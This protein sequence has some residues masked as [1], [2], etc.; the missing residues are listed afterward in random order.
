MPT[1]T[2]F[3]LLLMK[4]EQQEVA[5]FATR[6]AP[7]ANADIRAV[8]TESHIRGRI[9]NMAPWY[10]GRRKKGIFD[11]ENLRKMRREFQLCSFVCPGSPLS[12]ITSFS[13]LKLA[14]ESLPA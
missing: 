5:E 9:K 14:I 12:E 2:F 6:L 3:P 11:R 10:C 7:V 4:I 8:D 1:P 13:E